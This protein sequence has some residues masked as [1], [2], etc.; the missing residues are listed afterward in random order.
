VKR[1]RL[2]ALGGLTAALV[3]L[4][5]GPASAHVTLHSYDAVQGGSDALIA[6]RVPN[7]E[8]TATTTQLEVDFPAD[9]PLLGLN[10]QPTAGWQFQVTNSDLPTPIKTDDGTVTQYVSKVVWT[11]GSIPV[12]GYQ[13]FNIAVAN[14]P[15]APTVTVKAIQTYSN[16]DVVRWIDPPAATG[17]P[18][19]AHPAP[20]LDL[21]PAPADNTSGATATTTAPSGSSSSQSVKAVSLTGVAKTSDVNNATTVAVIALVIGVIALIV[22]IV[23][24]FVHRRTTTP[25]P[26]PS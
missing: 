11:G 12:G 22:A 25:P 21:P 17:Q 7:E 15:K 16:G 23:A 8:D 6:I 13:D 4:L 14:L 5:A 9:T 2:G 18:A 19:P 10:V 20:T 24:F 1:I 3:L 26:S